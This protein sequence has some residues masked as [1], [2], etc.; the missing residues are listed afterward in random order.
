MITIMIIIPAGNPMPGAGGSPVSLPFY[1][2]AHERVL[3][4]SCIPVACIRS[5]VLTKK[6]HWH[7]SQQAKK[8][9][10]SNWLLRQ[11][12][13]VVEERANLFTVYTHDD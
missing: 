8:V 1:V 3:T 6:R 2:K 7:C 5:C 13:Q 12:L 10:A 11:N 4:R 9:S